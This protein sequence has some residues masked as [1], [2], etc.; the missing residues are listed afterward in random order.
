MIIYH[1][2]KKLQVQKLNNKVN[3]L[4]A[5]V[6][7]QAR[8]F[9]CPFRLSTNFVTIFIKTSWHIVLLTI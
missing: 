3:L 6:Q 7:L 9:H 1:K 5:T 2:Q 8:N 4:N